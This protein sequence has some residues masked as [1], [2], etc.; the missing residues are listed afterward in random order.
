MTIV[1]ASDNAGKVKELKTILEAENIEVALQSQF[2]VKSVPETG[3]TFVEN[4]IIKARNCCEQTGMSAI[5]DDSGL[6]V[7][8][9]D[10]RPGVYSA[11]YAGEPANDTNNIKKLLLEL[12]DVPEEKRTARFQCVM[13]FLRSIFDPS[14]LIC[15][16]TWEGGIVFEPRGKKGFGYDPIFWVLEYNCTAA[17]LLPEIKNKISHRAK[18][19][20]LMKLALMSS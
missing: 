9:L 11:R 16:G 13:V 5:A 20:D 6:E 14:P 7:D 18:A 8:A 2:E 10:G 1:I 4:A 17:E 15:Q 19:L 12:R 3:L